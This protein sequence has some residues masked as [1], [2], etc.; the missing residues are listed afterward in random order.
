MKLQG[1]TNTFIILFIILF[2][3]ISLYFLID[4]LIKTKKEFK[5]GF[6]YSAGINDTNTHSVDMPLTNIYSCNNFCAPTSR[7]AITGQQCFSDIDCPGCQ[8]RTP[9]YSISSYK[10]E[11]PG[12]NDAG[13]LS[14]LGLQY[15][16]LTS[17]FG[18][19][20][21]S[22]NVNKN[23]KAP[24]ANF[25]DNVWSSKF[26]IDRKLFDERYKPSGLSNML[27]YPERYS[28]TG[29]FIDEGPIA[30]NAILN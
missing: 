30:S 23:S 7:C 6:N 10:Y 18:S 9:P 3:L 22:I 17:D 25:G 29:S 16:S 1:K 21:T 24:S 11:V 4:Y 20:S 12:T 14:N 13:K 28:L 26:N 5:E 8:P 15:S 27:V 19:R 2:F